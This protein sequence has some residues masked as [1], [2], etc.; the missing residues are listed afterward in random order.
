MATAGYGE[1]YRKHHVPLLELEDLNHRPLHLHHP[2][3]NHRQQVSRDKNLKNLFLCFPKPIKKFW[4][5][6]I[7][8]LCRQERSGLQ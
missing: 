6:F 7:S 2:P 8:S 3:G 5:I 1:W 4:K